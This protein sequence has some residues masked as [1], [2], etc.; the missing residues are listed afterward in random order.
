MKKLS[1]LLLC[2]L[3]AS[4]VFSQTVSKTKEI[5]KINPAKIIGLPDSVLRKAAAQL[6]MYDEYDK[7]F[8]YMND[9]ISLESYEI[10]LKDSIISEKN[11]QLADKADILSATNM[12]LSLSK[13]DNEAWKKKYTNLKINDR[14]KMGI[15][16][17]IIVGLLY[18]WFSKR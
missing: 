14:L 12:Q 13:A 10:H 9:N 18:A 8:A 15:G 11:K 6:V 2:L 3:T 5:N 4:L 16:G 7:A 17:T 1:T